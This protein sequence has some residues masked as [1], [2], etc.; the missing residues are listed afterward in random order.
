VEGGAVLWMETSRGP[1]L[2][3]PQARFSPSWLRDLRGGSTSGLTPSERPGEQ[4]L[5]RW[6]KDGA[7]FATELSSMAGLMSENM[8]LYRAA[9]DAV[10]EE[11]DGL[12]TLVCQLPRVARVLGVFVPEA[13]SRPRRILVSSD[14]EISPRELLARAG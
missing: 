4:L 2:W 14:L 3:I 1:V 5:E 8:P 10:A 6:L 7:P 9:W 13:G 12:S 11:Q